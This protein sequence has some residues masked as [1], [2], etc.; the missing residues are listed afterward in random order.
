M[1]R[2]WIDLP[3]PLVLNSAPILRGDVEAYS[4]RDG[5]I[6]TPH[7]RRIAR[8]IGLLERVHRHNLEV[9]PTKTLPPRTNEFRKT[10]VTNLQAWRSSSLS[11]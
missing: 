6:L 9:D 7:Q 4:V 5:A 2:P 8:R 10:A 1:A 3:G 11:G